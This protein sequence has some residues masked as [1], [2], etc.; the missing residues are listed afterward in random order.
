MQKR[1][2]RVVCQNLP[3]SHEGMEF[4]NPCT[5]L[6]RRCKSLP[7]PT[8]AFNDGSPVKAPTATPVVIII[9]SRTRM[10]KVGDGD[11]EGYKVQKGKTK[12]KEQ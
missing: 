6:Q 10:A 1:I 4:S 3:P 7:P 11:G 12:K 8:A 5:A 9:W 2:R